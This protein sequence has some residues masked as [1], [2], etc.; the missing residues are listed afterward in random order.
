MRPEIGGQLL[1]FETKV[2]GS[3]HGALRDLSSEGGALIL[4]LN[5]SDEPE[6]EN[7]CSGLHCSWKGRDEVALKRMDEY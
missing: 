3:T 4:C 5:N 6:G 2:V 1:C 7:G